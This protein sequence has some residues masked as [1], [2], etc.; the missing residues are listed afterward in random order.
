MSDKLTEQPQS[1]IP[2][3]DE[4]KL[5]MLIRLGS[6]F[7]PKDFTPSQAKHL[8]IDY[9]EDL[10]KY[11]VVEIEH[12]CRDWRTNISKKN[13]PKVAEIIAAVGQSRR[14]I[15]EAAAARDRPKIAT[16]PIRWWMQS[17]RCWNPI[18]LESEVPAGE[19][20]RDVPGGP[21][22]WPEG[23]A[24]ENGGNGPF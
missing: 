22:R 1:H 9:L 21:L 10:K 5:Q 2:G 4:Q 7:W 18:W 11:R 19:K 13:F 8:L 3:D 23:V 17:K 14:D 24:A 16:R 6:H 12:F 15:A 20:I